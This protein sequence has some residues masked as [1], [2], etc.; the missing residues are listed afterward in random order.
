MVV[1]VAFLHKKRAG[2]QLVKRTCRAVA[3]CCAYLLVA[4]KIHQI[5][6]VHIVYLGSPEPLGAGSLLLAQSPPQTFP[7]L[8][9]CAGEH[10]YATVTSSAIGIIHTILHQN[11]GIGQR[12]GV[13]NRSLCAG[14]EYGCCGHKKG[15]CKAF[16]H[17]F[18]V[19]FVNIMGKVTNFTA[20][21]P[22][23]FL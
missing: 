6:A 21:P 20:F 12:Q 7:V 15:K 10:F 18:N 8:K 5:S 19:I 2:I 14:L 16:H 23:H 13:L 4:G 3:P 17:D 11:V 1:N 22:N 9:V